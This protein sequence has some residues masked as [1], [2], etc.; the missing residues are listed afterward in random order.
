MTAAV[1]ANSYYAMQPLLYRVLGV[2]VVVLLGLFVVVNTTEG[3][4]A[5][6]II[7]DSRTEIRRV[8]WP[9]RVETIQTTLIVLVAITI[10]GVMLWAMDSLFGWA[11]AS[12][13][14]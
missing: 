9:T 2:V 7:L 12:L 10:A 8:I 3:K 6:K 5:M 1:F 4:E 11:T 14:G 13:L